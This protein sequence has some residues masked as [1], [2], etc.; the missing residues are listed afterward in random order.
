V[1]SARC[2]EALK[3]AKRAVQEEASAAVGVAELVLF[4]L[5]AQRHASTLAARK[6]EVAVQLPPP[7]AAALPQPWVTTPM[8]ITQ[9]KVDYKFRARADAYTGS[10][11]HAGLVASLDAAASARLARRK[12]AYL[13]ATEVELI[14]R[15]AGVGA[16]ASAGGTKGKE[17]R[18]GKESK[19]VGAAGAEEVLAVARF[20]LASL[21]ERGS[22]LGETMAPLPLWAPRRSRDE[23]ERAQAEIEAADAAA[24]KAAMAE[25]KADAAA[26]PDAKADAKTVGGELIAK[27]DAKADAKAKA[28]RAARAAVERAEKSGQLGTLQVSSEF[29]HALRLAERQLQARRSHVARRTVPPVPPAALV[30]SSPWLFSNSRGAGG[31]GARLGLGG[32]GGMGAGLGGLGSGGMPP[33]GYSAYEPRLDAAP[34][35][36]PPRAMPPFASFESAHHGAAF[37]SARS[38]GGG[39]G[40]S[41]P[42]YS[43]YA[44]RSSADAAGM[45]QAPLTFPRTPVASSFTAYSRRAAADADDHPS[46]R[47]RRRGTLGATLVADEAG[48]A[49]ERSSPSRRGGGVDGALAGDLARRPPLGLNASVV[50]ELEDDDEGDA[51]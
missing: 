9:G 4:P 49:R 27:A 30:P 8:R 43:E 7:L 1:V 45:G 15:V 17:G 6:V 2:L 31:M 50:G 29:L 21:M 51:Y 38:G 19:D 28:A 26:P 16:A 23:I 12:A 5:T 37:E 39:G 44:I 48:P 24:A 20:S 14:V 42:A 40:A 41:L 34:P 10:A 25:A 32:A 11:V 47:P 22:D 36:R 46:T 33:L 13:Q 35:T 18:D 3:W